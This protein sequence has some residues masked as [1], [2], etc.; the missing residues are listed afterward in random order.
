MLAIG[1]YLAQ[2]PG[3][4]GSIISPINFN[5]DT[6]TQSWNNLKEKGYRDYRLRPLMKMDLQKFFGIIIIMAIDDYDLK[7]NLINTL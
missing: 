1:K 4:Y 2:W 7:K 3:Q 6:Q 5:I